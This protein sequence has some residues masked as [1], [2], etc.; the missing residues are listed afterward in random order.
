MSGL[1]PPPPEG[2]SALPVGT[3][4]GGVVIVTGGGTGLG[5]AIAVEFARLG[6]SVAIVQWLRFGSGGFVRMVGFAPKE[7]WS[8]SFPRF[9]AIRDGVVPR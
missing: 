4:D 9:R 5:K 7:T 3:F 1:L 8:E 2:A 6:A